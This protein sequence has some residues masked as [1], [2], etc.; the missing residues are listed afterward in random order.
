MD[1][2]KQKRQRDFKKSTFYITPNLLRFNPNLNFKAIDFCSEVGMAMTIEDT[3][4]GNEL[5]DFN[6]R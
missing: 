3:W 2:P 6:H 5:F 4:G 1:L